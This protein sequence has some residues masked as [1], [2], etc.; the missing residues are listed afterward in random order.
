MV[1]NII[2]KIILLLILILYLIYLIIC[3]NLKICLKDNITLVTGLFNIKSKFKI[4]KYLNWVENLLLLNASIVFFMD[5]DIANIIRKKRPKIYENKTIWI[6]TSISEFYAFQYIKDFIKSYEIDKENSYHTISLYLIWAEKCNFLRKAI[7]HNYFQSKCFY[8]I[9]GGY[10]RKKYINKTIGWP[11]INKCIKDPRV[12]INSIRKVQDNEIKGLKQFN[13]SIY[14]EFIKKP[15]VAGGLFGGQVK[16]LIKFIDLYYKTIKIY[17]K[18][19]MFIGKDQNIFAYIS[20]LNPNLVNLVHSGKWH[21]FI[22][23]L[24]K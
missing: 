19:N 15:N 14:N 7:Y 21:Y 9:D 1:L 8:W 24:S 18:H 3:K 4:D 20:Y 11:S 22:N 23:Y 17:I 6:E 16:Y 12:L 13:N 2:Y 5:K 10:F